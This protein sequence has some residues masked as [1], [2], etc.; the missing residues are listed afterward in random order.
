MA[1]RFT[2]GCR[3]GAIRYECS[4]EPVISSNCHCRDCQWATGSAFAPMLLVPRSAVTITGDI[5]Y[6]D[7]TGESGNMVSRGFC[8]ACGTPLCGKGA[9]TPGL[10]GL[11]AGSLDDPSWYRPAVDIYTASAQPW[12]YMNPALRKYERAPTAEQIQELLTS[13]G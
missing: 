8:A 5:K 6:Y 12:D 11:R 2:G 13:G 9:L 10:I 4:A 3:C 1:T 7:V